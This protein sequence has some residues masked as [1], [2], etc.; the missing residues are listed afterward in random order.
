MRVST[1]PVHIQKL[2]HV[3]LIPHFKLIQRV[4]ANRV[5]I[6]IVAIVGTVVVGAAANSVVIDFTYAFHCENCNMSE[7]KQEKR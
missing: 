7:A 3:Y 1:L 6:I 4:A 2:L 5:V